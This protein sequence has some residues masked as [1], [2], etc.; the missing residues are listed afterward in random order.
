VVGEQLFLLIGDQFGRDHIKVRRSGYCLQGGVDGTTLRQEPCDFDELSQSWDLRD[1]GEIVNVFHHGCLEP[2]QAD[3]K[4][5][6]IV[7]SFCDGTVAQR[8]LF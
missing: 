1:T 7:S 4:N 5:A 8:W 3:T 6:D 2:R